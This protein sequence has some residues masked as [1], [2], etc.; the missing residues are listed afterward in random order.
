MKPG[1]PGLASETWESTNPIN[2]YS[3]STL[4]KIAST[5]PNCRV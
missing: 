5:F 4:S 3:P 1:A 2:P